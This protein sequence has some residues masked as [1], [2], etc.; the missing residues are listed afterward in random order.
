MESLHS[1]SGWH[2]VHNSARILLGLCAFCKTSEQ[3]PTRLGKN[4]RRRNATW[5]KQSHDFARL[6]Q[7]D[8]RT[9]PVPRE[10]DRIQQSDGVVIQDRRDGGTVTE[11]N[12]VQQSD[13][14]VKYRTHRATP[15]FGD[16]SRENLVFIRR[17]KTPGRV[18]ALGKTKAF[19][20]SVGAMEH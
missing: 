1:F 19:S 20:I 16:F 11:P 4:F 10:P 14:V 8:G 7:M 5:P 3:P 15:G 13:V 2:I 18:A 9:I 6:A 12:I 17:S